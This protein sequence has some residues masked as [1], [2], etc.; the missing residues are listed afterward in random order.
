MR[1]IGL[2]TS[3]NRKRRRRLRA[4]TSTYPNALTNS[5]E[6]HAAA[7]RD[8]EQRPRIDRLASNR[9][10]SSAMGCTSTRSV[11][12]DWMALRLN[13]PRDPW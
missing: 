11:D 3:E 1:V 6:Q 12:E 10:R 9:V 5:P 2:K 4:E 8:S 13:T 7:R